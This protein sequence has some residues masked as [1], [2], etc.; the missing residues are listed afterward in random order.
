MT[1]NEG[2]RHGSFAGTSPELSQGRGAK[3]FSADAADARAATGATR[4]ELA[5]FERLADAWWDTEGP[6]RPLHLMN[7][8]RIGYICD[9]AARHL[10]R[11]GPGLRP[12]QGV[13]L[14]DVGCGGGLLAEPLARLGGHVT[15]IDLE[16]RLVET[17]RAHAQE[18]DLVIDFRV[19]RTDDLI[20]QGE[21][22][23]VVI[24]SEVVEHVADQQAFLASLAYLARPGG[25]IVLSTLAR[26]LR[27]LGMAIV[28]AEYL[29]RW[30]PVGTHDWRH[31]L[32]PAELAARLR[33]AGLVPLDV[34]GIG[35][36]AAHARFHKQADVR[37]NYM[38][39][40]KRF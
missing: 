4:E 25:L 30:L 27:S 24:A 37:V 21:L 35:Y 9:Q 20:E 16:P 28:G 40:A 10:G 11:Q 31:F 5:K 7:P 39:S 15:G 2:K 14:L 38:M 18:G 32:S 8:V 17:A 23:D 19:A 3:H 22:F 13:R 36:D 6:M 12:L 29:L 1:M 26:T 33:R 34:T